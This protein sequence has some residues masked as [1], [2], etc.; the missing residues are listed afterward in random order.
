VM[1][2][3]TPEQ[4][5]GAGGPAPGLTSATTRQAGL[6]SNVDVPATVVRYVGHADP[7]AGGSPI[8][9][10]GFVPTDL[11]RTY[12]QYR[13][14]VTPVGVA[15]LAVAVVA[16][17]AALAI[18]LGAWTPRR[19]VGA[20]VAVAALFAVSLQVAMLPGSWLPDYSW[21]VVVGTLVGVA[22]VV[23]AAAVW[24]DRRSPHAA[25]A[26]IAVAGAAL[27][28]VDWL[29]GWRSLLTPL[30]G[31]SALEGTRFYGLGNS[32]AG[33]LV[34]GLVLGAAMLP[35]TAGVAVL[36][37]GAVFAG[38]PWT[39]SDLGGG[40][41]LFVAA[42]LWWSL[43]VR[44]RLGPREMVAV[45]GAAVVG[46]AVLVLL[47]RVAPDPSHV[48]R[49]A[50]GSGG[51]ILGTFLERLRLNLE[52]TARTPVVWPALAG[53]VVATVAAWRRWPAFEPG[54]GGPPLWRP[55]AMTLGA[56]AIAGYVLNDTYGLAAVA[57][58][59]LSLALIYPS[60][61]EKCSVESEKNHK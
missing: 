4:L 26:T 18:V 9:V 32:Y 47:H 27:V 24:A 50:E 46:A 51:E 37:A 23:T 17:G 53:L 5:L 41:T 2:W 10:E 29:L 55:A 59:Y 48:S 33:V 43:A 3:G 44:R 15:V 28:L 1:G 16:L 30:L 36:V 45:L 40:T 11:S 20:A 54:F 38:S 49:V 52:I 56:A 60:M 12:L 22:G 13:S 57:F 61:V 42:A 7:G 25:V 14:V 6:V 35:P 21:P 31:G 8:E 39:G 34:A 19:R 58:V